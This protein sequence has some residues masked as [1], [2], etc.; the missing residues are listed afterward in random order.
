MTALETDGFKVLAVWSHQ[1]AIVL[2]R[3][4]DLTQFAKPD[5]VSNPGKGVA[6]RSKCMTADKRKAARNR[7]QIR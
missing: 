6:S 3:S 1:G 4:R 5:A 2:R 7:W